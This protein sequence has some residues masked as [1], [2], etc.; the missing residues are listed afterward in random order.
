MRRDFLKLINLWWTISNNKQRHRT[1][2]RTV[3]AAVEGDNKLL[4]LREF[5]NW[6][7]RCQALPGQNS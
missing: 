3:D 5:A 6:L 2:F 4:F 7:E 1:N